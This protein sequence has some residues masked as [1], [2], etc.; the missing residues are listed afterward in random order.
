MDVLSPFIPVV[1]HSDWLFQGESCPRLDVVH[2]GR[3]FVFLACVHLA[4]FLAVCCRSLLSNGMNY[5][6]VTLLSNENRQHLAAGWTT[7]AWWRWPTSACHESWSCRTTIAC[8]TARLRSP[9]AG[10]RQSRSALTSSPPWATSYDLLLIV[11]SP[12]LG[13][14]VLRWACLS[15]CLSASIVSP[16]LH[17]SLRQILRLLPY[18]TNYFGMGPTTWIPVQDWSTA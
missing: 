15:V 8:V 6:V 11:I 18:Q 7:E 4:L 12:T 9:F 16:E 1:C 17:P 14:E 10:W 2:P 3:A 5:L 13:S